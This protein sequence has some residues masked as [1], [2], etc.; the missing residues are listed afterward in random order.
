LIRAAAIIPLYNHRDTIAHHRPNVRRFMRNMESF[1]A[2]Q[3]LKLGRAR[4]GLTLGL[5]TRTDRHNWRTQ[6]ECAI[7]F[8][9]W[10]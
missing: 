10:I 6:L 7:A 5:T 8:A 4:E 9:R 1:R 2:L 3:L